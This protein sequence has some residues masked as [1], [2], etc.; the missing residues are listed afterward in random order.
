MVSYSNMLHEAVV[1][2][3]LL[4][5]VHAVYLIPFPIAFRCRNWRMSV[6]SRILDG[7]GQ[8]VIMVDSIPVVFHHPHASVLSKDLK[9][10]VR[11]SYQCVSNADPTDR[12]RLQG[13]PTLKAYSAPHT[14]GTSLFALVPSFLS[15]HSPSGDECLGG[16]RLPDSALT[17]AAE[18]IER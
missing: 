14:S 15:L 16:G 9:L 7:M 5:I 11:K 2:L 4:Y 13:H 12:V 1:I 6:L 17:R 3:L 10:S 8:L 18:L